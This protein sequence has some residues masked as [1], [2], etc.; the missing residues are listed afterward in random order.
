M[1]V[2]KPMSLS[3]SHTKELIELATKQQ[4]VFVMEGMWTRCFPA[5]HKLRK[6]IA[7]EEIGP[8]VYV[9]GDFGYAFPSTTRNDTNNDSP[10]PPN[11]DRIWYPNSGG[12]TLDV[13]MYIAQFGRI[14]F[15][16]RVKTVQA[17]G[18][19]K[20]GVDYSVM[21]TVTYDRSVVQ[22]CERSKPEGGGD[23]NSSKSSDGILRGEDTV[24]VGMLQMVL[25]GASNT[26]E[27]CVL[28]GTKGRI[29]LDEPFHIP[30]RLRVIYNDDGRRRGESGIICSSSSSSC[31]RRDGNINEVVYD[32]PLPTDSYHGEWNNPGSIGLVYQINEVGNA[33]RMGKTE[34]DSF[35]WQ[36]S[37]DV[38]QI[39]DEIVRQV[40][41]EQSNVP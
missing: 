36:D 7:S 33:L 2:E 38:A 11:N 22:C 37:L 4:T 30:Q 18:S 31:S 39:L 26:E 12:I 28:Q 35:T 23:N 21:A 16:G 3:Y 17:V 1:V 41:G 8:I 15:N 27:R 10:T 40:R 14:A 25:T 6:F 19:M 9:Q 13:G 32:F 5:M 34:C 20:N 24:Q 29:I